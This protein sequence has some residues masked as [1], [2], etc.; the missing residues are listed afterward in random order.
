MLREGIKTGR[1]TGEE[2]SAVRVR[3][4]AGVSFWLSMTWVL[5][6]CILTL[7]ADLLPL[8]EHDRM[9]FSQ[10]SVAPG[11]PFLQEGAA[12]AGGENVPGQY[13]YLL[14]TDTLGRDLASRVIRG[15]RVSLTVG[16]V[17]PL[18]GLSFG[19]ILGMAA[20]YYRGRVEAA[21][22][23]VTDVILA[24]PNL[25][26]LLGVTFILGPSLLNLVIGLGIVTIP[27][28][29]R[30]A[31]A[32]TI[33]YTERDFILAAKMIGRSDGA[34]IREE[35]LPNIF[36]P[37]AVYALVVVSYMIVAE[38]ALSYLGLS[39]RPP[40]PS[41]G[42]MVAEGRE[43]LAEAAHVSMIPA[44]AMTLTVLSFNLIADTLQSALDKR[45]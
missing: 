35:I 39:V 24:F 44:L 1:Q 41:W 33:K 7:A 38:G 23:I 12:F 27:V 32:N 45:R 29:T 6:V 16:L 20:G 8:L 42:G 4:R 31:R 18:L 11:T 34:I 5:L 3:L 15:G 28:F 36:L 37:V 26:L 9:N 2:P 17:S 22:G 13:L 40:I 14:G 43:V 25:V 19:L 21:V 10:V 30:I